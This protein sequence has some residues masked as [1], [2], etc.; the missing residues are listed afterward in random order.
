LANTPSFTRDLTVS[1]SLRD[2]L[3][4]AGFKDKSPNRKKKQAKSGQT[5]PKSKNA[6]ATSN[7]ANNGKGKNQSQGKDEA[8]AIA[9]RKRIKAEIKV[10]IESSAIKDIAGEIPYNF[11][12]GKKVR[13]LFVNEAAQKKL[14]SGE[15]VITRLNGNTHLIP[16]DQAADILK[17]NPDWAIVDNKNS[18]TTDGD[19]NGF[20]VP[21]DLM[22]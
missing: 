3:L 14:T 12:L 10:L 19:Y 1:D 20:D 4:Q 8:A 5:K 16:A 11:V 21:D 17:L 6:K 7:Q 18:D 9:E 22:W 13:Q 15:V 2:Q